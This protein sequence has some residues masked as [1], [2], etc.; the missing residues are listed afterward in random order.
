MQRITKQI[1]PYMP[2]AGC[3]LSGLLLA[4]V[5]PP[6]AQ[7]QAA[8]LALVPGLMAARAL[9]PRKAFLGG[10]LAGATGWLF[11]MSWLT[12]VTVAG[13]LG[14][15]LY[16]GLF[17]G[18]FFLLVSWWVRRYSAQRILPNLLLMILCVVTWTGF[19]F[20]RSVFA[21]GFAWNTLGTSQAENIP[22]L[23][24]A[25]LGG[26][27]LISALI[28]WMNA[29]VAVSL[30]RYWEARGR[31]KRH[32]HPEFLLGLLA[33]A[34]AFSF[35]WRS[36]LS[37]EPATENVQ[38]ALVQPNIPQEQKWL[39]GDFTAEEY[40]A[41]CAKIYSRLHR[42]TLPLT[43]VEGL[44]LIVWPETAI[45]DDLLSSVESYDL[46]HG[47]VT[48]GVPI[49]VGSMD[50]EW[51]DDGSRRYYNCSFL[52]GASGRI[53]QGY[54]KQ[55]LVMFGE[56][57]PLQNSIPFLRAITPIQES[58]SPGTNSTLFQVESSSAFFS[59]L[60][61]FEDSV[62]ALARRAVKKGARMLVNQTNDA[63]FDPSSGSRQHLWHSILRA[64]ENGVPVVRS[65][66]TGISGVIDRR[67]R[68]L[69][70][71]QQN[72]Q[73][74]CVEGVAL[75]PVPVPGPDMALTP[76]TQYGDEVWY[77]VT[78]LAVLLQ[79][80]IWAN[81]RSEERKKKAGSTV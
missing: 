30:M 27:Y 31:P 26:V 76:Y 60:I 32:W 25:R 34:L 42:L 59:V 1:R 48:N 6:L 5:F 69:A 79:V 45:P 54:D 68:L 41:F 71:V 64:V 29:G 33:W 43:Q 22:V 18:P 15:S 63:W 80:F 24:V 57:V 51:L 17:V 70:A 74:D 38:V 67:G 52:V 12:Y 50:T 39:T 81:L 72:G 21:T 36:L 75:F 44:Q 16:C 73:M 13:W 78:G 37:G 46:V 53:M 28:V 4:A 19:E 35:G 55:H 9:P 49:L 2:W 47:L 14:L 8:W 77:G 10:V 3:V 7:G 66:N 61:C 56:Y 58:F 65:A 40:T 11:S 62:S 20:A 23:Q